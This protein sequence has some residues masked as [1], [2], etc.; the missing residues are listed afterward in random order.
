MPDCATW[1]AAALHSGCPNPTIWNYSGPWTA[2]AGT[3]AAAGGLI[4]AIRAGFNPQTG[5]PASA[6][7]MADAAVCY[8]PIRPQPMPINW[9]NFGLGGAD[10]DGDGKPESCDMFCADGAPDVQYPYPGHTHYTDYRAPG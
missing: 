4:G 6:L 7:L 5:D 2:S 9:W 1:N 3:V 8:A 10:I